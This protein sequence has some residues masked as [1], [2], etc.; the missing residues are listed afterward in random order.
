[1]TRIA[2]L[3]G[4][5]LA[6]VAP[7]AGAVCAGDCG[8]DGVVTI[9]ELISGVNIALGAVGQCASFDT[10]SDGTVAI[11]ELVAA[12]ANA[13]NGCPFTGRYAARVDVGDGE[14]GLI[15][16]QVAPDGTATGTLEVGPTGSTSGAALHLEIPLLNLTGTVDLDTGAYHL[17]GTVAGNEGDVPVDVSGTL[18]DRTGLSGTL[19]LEIGDESFGGPIVAG[20]GNPTP[21]PT[22][23]RPATTPT[24]T[25]TAIPASFPTPPGNTCLNGS[26]SLVFRDVNGANSYADLGHGLAI[27]KGTFNNL[28][29]IVFGGGAVPCTLMASDILRRVQLTYIG[30]GAVEGGTVPLGR[31]G[32]KATFDYLEAPATNPLGT[33]G[34]RSDSG[35]LVIDHLDA[36][37]VRFHIIGAVM[38]PEPSFSGQ[39]PATGTIT[40]DAGAEGTFQ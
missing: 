19:D 14:T 26:F 2:I 12:V 18:P 38:S 22:N 8:G 37:S 15:R 31:G 25:F 20:N 28:P 1:M 17:T 13:L 16:L 35:S 32:G 29:G 21:T 27:Q 33:R 36:T 39:T 23:T 30:A 7:R 24:P 40:I 11:N 9:N 10:N 34:W 4:L 3:V 6:L 5:M